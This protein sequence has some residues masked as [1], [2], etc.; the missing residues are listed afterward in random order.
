MSHYRMQEVLDKISVTWWNKV[1]QRYVLAQFQVCAKAV[2]GM[3][4][5]SV[6]EGSVLFWNLALH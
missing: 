4:L 3:C 6:P 2:P 1:P 5:R